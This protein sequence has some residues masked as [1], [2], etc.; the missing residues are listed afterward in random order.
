MFHKIWSLLLLASSMNFCVHSSNLFWRF[1]GFSRK[2]H[3]SVLPLGTHPSPVPHNSTVTTHRFRKYAF[4]SL[5]SVFQPQHCLTV[6]ETLPDVLQKYIYK[7]TSICRLN[8]PRLTSGFACPP[9]T[10]F[11]HI[12]AGRCHR[13]NVSL[14]ALTLEYSEVARELSELEVL[15]R[16]YLEVAQA[17]GLLGIGRTGSAWAVC[18]A[19]HCLRAA[20]FAFCYSR[21]EPR[22]QWSPITSLQSHGILSAVSTTGLNLSWT[23]VIGNGALKCLI[24]TFIKR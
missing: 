2:W 24:L 10:W 23:V 12:G 19:L 20:I 7:T 8:I 6:F 14:C 18:T 3:C 13:A 21:D 1:W 5:F 4:V 11:H 22:S 17:A 9:S 16:C 15:E